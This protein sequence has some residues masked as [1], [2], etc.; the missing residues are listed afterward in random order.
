M[1]C[2]NQQ[3][4]LSDVLIPLPLWLMPQI[5][6]CNYPGHGLWKREKDMHQSILYPGSL[7]FET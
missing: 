4:L 3:F 2:L 5:V 7:K 1:L 6:A